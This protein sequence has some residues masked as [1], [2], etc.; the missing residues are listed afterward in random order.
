MGIAELSVELIEIIGDLLEYDREINALACTNKHLHKV[1]NPWLYG[2]N[3]MSLMAIA[4]KRGH[5]PLARMLLDYLPRKGDVD[6]PADGLRRTPLI[7]VAEM[8]R[9]PVVRCLVDA[10]ANL[11]TRDND[12]QTPLAHAARTGHHEV[13]EFLLSR[14]ADPNAGSY[15][16]T[17]P[18]ISEAAHHGYLECVRCLINADGVMDSLPSLNETITPSC[19]RR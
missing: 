8:G 2:Y 6:F 3:T 14:G 1:R 5:E 16:G 7:G 10:G 11:E 12:D 9:L 19:V 18:P 15:S 4:A 17:A 13:V